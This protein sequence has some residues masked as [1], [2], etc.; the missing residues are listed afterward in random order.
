MMH[1]CQHTPP[2]INSLKLDMSAPY[3]S[4]PVQASWQ[5]SC[6]LNAVAETFILA[7]IQRAKFL[8]GTNREKGV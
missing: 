6:L 3:Q 8:V 2:K 1:Y 5:Q 7:L 4:E